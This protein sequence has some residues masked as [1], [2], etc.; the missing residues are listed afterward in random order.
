MSSLDEKLKQVDERL[1]KK[2]KQVDELKVAQDELIKVQNEQNALVQKI[3]D[4]KK[5][6]FADK[7]KELK[8]SLESILTQKEFVI[9]KKD[10]GF[11]ADYKGIYSIELVDDKEKSI[12]ITED[13]KITKTVIYKFAIKGVFYN[14]DKMY[15]YQGHSE[16]DKTKEMIRQEKEYTSRYEEMYEKVKSERI[17][18]E[19]KVKTKYVRDFVDRTYNDIDSFIESLFK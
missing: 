16:L 9:N 4:T 5:K 3:M 6:L 2:L 10:N 18:I 11:F 1:E 19:A 13:Q 14:F 17:I 8:D 7:N 12:T 15:S